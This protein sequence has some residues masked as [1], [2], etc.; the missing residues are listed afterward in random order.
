MN[1]GLGLAAAK[2]VAEEHSGRLDISRQ[3]EGFDINMA[4]PM[5]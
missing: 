2:N 1:R 4:W 5:L 3:S